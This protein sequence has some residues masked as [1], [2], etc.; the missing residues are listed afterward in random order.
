MTLSKIIKV[1]Q[2]HKPFLARKYGIK[3]IGIFGSYAR[4][5]QHSKSDLDILVDIDISSN[6]SL[7][8]LIELENYLSKKT[9]LKVDLAVKN[10]LRKR[11]GRRILDEVQYI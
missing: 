2:N 10:N 1:I 6:L 4:K 11:I 7:L 8:D 9:G 3:E 5:K